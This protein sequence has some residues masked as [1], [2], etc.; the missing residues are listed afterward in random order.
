MLQVSLVS[1]CSAGAFLSLA[2]FDFPWHIIAILV[3]LK[4]FLQNNLIKD[5]DT[6]LSSRQA[7][8]R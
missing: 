1:Y 5:A 2:Y 3:L 4:V 8:L 6:D 7:F